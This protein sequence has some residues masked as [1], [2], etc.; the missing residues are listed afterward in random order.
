VVLVSRSLAVC[1]AHREHRT[2]WSDASREIGWILTTGS[3]IVS[4]GSHNPCQSLMGESIMVGNK[5][6]DSVCE[7]QLPSLLLIWPD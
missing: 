1:V 4:N 6:I 3:L 7:L 5:K 2:A